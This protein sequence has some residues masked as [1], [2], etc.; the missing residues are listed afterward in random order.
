MPPDSRT[1]FFKVVGKGVLA[2][3]LL[4]LVASV[5]AIP[6]G[7]SDLTLVFLL[8]ASLLSALFTLLIVVMK[9]PVPKTAPYPPYMFLICL[10]VCAIFL[11]F[12]DILPEGW[13]PSWVMDHPLS[14]LLS[15]LAAGFA[16]LTLDRRRRKD[17]PPN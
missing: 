17:R 14:T 15:L 2:C 5:L 1:K 8:S 4:L 12:S 11:Y 9:V 6:V 7:R 13:R 16:L 3:A 10:V